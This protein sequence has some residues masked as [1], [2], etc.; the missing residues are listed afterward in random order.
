MEAARQLNENEYIDKNKLLKH[1]NN[2]IRDTNNVYF[3]YFKTS[4]NIYYVK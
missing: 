3:F 1:W 4:Y 2:I